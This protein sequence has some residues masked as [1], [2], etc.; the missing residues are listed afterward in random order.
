MQCSAMRYSPLCVIPQSSSTHLIIHMHSH[1]DQVELASQL[2]VLFKRSLHKL[3]LDVARA[4]GAD[5]AT[6]ASIQQR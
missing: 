4:D 1:T 6:I 3:A 5:L 2:D